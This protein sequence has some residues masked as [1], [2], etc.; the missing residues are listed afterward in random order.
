M[1]GRGAVTIPN[2]AQ[3]IKGAPIMPWND[4]KQLMIEYSTYET[5][6]A[7]EKYFPQRLKQWFK[8]ISKQYVESED[9]FKE[10]RS[11][12]ETSHIVKLLNM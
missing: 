6:G 1:I 10:I 8:Y 2:L 12:K 5:L 7:K 11:V 4:V 3:H 9:L